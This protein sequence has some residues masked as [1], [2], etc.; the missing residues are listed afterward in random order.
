MITA[1][2]SGQKFYQTCFR[3]AVKGSK[4]GRLGRLEEHIIFPALLYL[5]GPTLAT[6]FTFSMLDY[7]AA[8]YSRIPHTDVFIVRDLMGFCLVLVGREQG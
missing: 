8:L 5:K 3:L 6:N 1:R 4:W 2:R 7:L